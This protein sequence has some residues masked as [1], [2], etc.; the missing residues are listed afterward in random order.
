MTDVQEILHDLALYNCFLYNKKK[1]TN[2]SEALCFSA[3]NIDTTLD[4]IAYNLSTEK[5]FIL[6][7]TL[8]HKLPVTTLTKIDMCKTYVP[9]ILTIMLHICKSRISVT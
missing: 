2:V 9:C 8:T 4:C 5:E 7:V 1:L 6:W 3:S